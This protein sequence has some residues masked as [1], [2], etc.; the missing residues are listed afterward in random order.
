MFIDEIE[1]YVCSGRGGDGMVHF[2]REKY[3]NRG[4]PDGGD[5]GR[6]GDVILKASE[7]FNTLNA[8]RHKSRF[9]AKNGGRGATN[10]STGRSAE[11]LEILVPMGTMV[12]D[13]TSKELLGDLVKHNDVLV[14]C[15]GGRGGRGNQH[16]ASPHNQAPRVGEKGEPGE[17]RLLKLELKLI[18][19]VGI[20][21]VPN[22]GK[23]SLLAAVTGAHPKIANYPF[24]TLEPNLGWL[25]WTWI[26]L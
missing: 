19:D 20:V 6:G 7:H 10:N 23:S 24:T 2:H 4:G 22:A 8:F 18:A 12:F 9:I 17:D 11:H 21:G 26:P 5:G 15:R 14:I 16:F 3:V 25:N 13:S 1:I